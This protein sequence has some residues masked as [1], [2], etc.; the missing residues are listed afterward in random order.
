MVLLPVRQY[1]L[2]LDSATRH[3][4]RMC[5]SSTVAMAIKYLIPTALSGS[6]ADDD[7]LKTVLTFGDTTEAN[8]QIKAASRYGVEARFYKNGTKEKLL[9]ELNAGYPVATGILHKGPSTAPTG[10]GHWMLLIGLTDDSGIFH[11]PYGRMDEIRGG[12]VTKGLG[13][14][15]VKYHLKHWLP[16]WEVDGKATGWYITFRTKEP[17][18]PNNWAGV[19][20]AAKDAGAKFPEVVAAQWALESDWGS[21][22]SGKNNYFGIKSS[23]KTGTLLRTSE[24][25]DGK[26]VKID[27]WFKDFADL[28]EC[29]NDLVTKWYKDYKQYKGVNRASDSSECAKLLVQEGYATDPNYAS[30][31]INIIRGQS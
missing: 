10:D 11:D 8:S 12:Y 26:E 29:V 27:A 18:Y 1:Y 21:A 17:T 28:R 23:D 22:P 7:Y 13:G 6:N 31:L 9:S 5:F 15:D 19:F 3:G 20:A 14:K 4:D 16:R 25:Y 30:K 24:F 2:Q